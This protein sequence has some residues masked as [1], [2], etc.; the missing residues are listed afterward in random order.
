MSVGTSGS[1]M[2]PNPFFSLN[3]FTVPFAIHSTDRARRP[4][5]EVYLLGSYQGGAPIIPPISK[6]STEYKVRLN[7]VKQIATYLSR[8]GYVLR[9]GNYAALLFLWLTWQ[10]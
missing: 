3:H 4:V 2:N 10:R 5:N 7:N 9:S 6:G 8:A 1:T